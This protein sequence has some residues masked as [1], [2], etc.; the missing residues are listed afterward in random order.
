[1]IEIAEKNEEEKRHVLIALQDILVKNGYDARSCKRDQL[2]CIA[3]KC[4][5]CKYKLVHNEI[6]QSW[7]NVILIAYFT[8]A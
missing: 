3:C 1:M 5:W 4:N 8:T 7:K 2:K 6:F